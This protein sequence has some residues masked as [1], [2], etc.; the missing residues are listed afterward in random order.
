[1]SRLLM[2]GICLVVCGM[3]SV[4]AVEREGLNWDHQR[5]NFGHL[6]IDYTVYHDFKLYNTGPRPIHVD[7]VTID[8]D[9]SRVDLRD[10]VIAPLDTVDVRVAFNTRDYFGPVTKAMWVYTDDPSV[11]M[12]QMFY[13]AIVGQW[14]DGLKPQP[15]SLFFLP[16]HREVSVV[17]SNPAL[18]QVE[19]NSLEPFD[20]TFTASARVS[21]AGKDEQLEITV[22]P[23]DNLTKGTYNT[24]LRVGLASGRDEPMFLSIPVKIVR[25]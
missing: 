22:T 13:S 2:T 21:A 15:A 18:D 14:Y 6:G 19:V 10:S 3:A 24:C 1:M 25:Y 7:S 16:A 4:H 11:P 17:I 5:Y 8:C 20:S 12:V 9:C 23:S